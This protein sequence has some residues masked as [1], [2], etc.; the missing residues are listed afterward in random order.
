MKSLR[1]GLLLGTLV[2]VCACA[3]GSE[4]D[5][6][7]GTG[8]APLGTGGA[9]GTGGVPGTGGAALGTGGVPL[10]TGGVP[11]GTGGVPVGT[12]GVA[13]TGGTSGGSQQDSVF[14]TDGYGTSGD[15][16]GYLFTAIDE[17]GST[18][19]PVCGAA[20]SCY[21][22]SGK[23]VCASGNLTAADDSFVMIGF[24]LNQ[25]TTPPNDPVA[26]TTTGTG[27]T[28]TVANPGNTDLRIKVDVGGTEYCAPLQKV[29]TAQTISW[30]A[31]KTACWGSSGTTL[32][33]SS[34]IQA[35]A[36]QVPGKAAG[37][38]PYNYCL[39]NIAAA[40]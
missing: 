17:N 33:A 27:V 28:V 39:V 19:A 40:P 15:W 11:L 35:I 16:H 21:S 30:A 18:V 20:G 13:A 5:D 36:V 8:G 24:N 9:F 32:P 12:G 7:A 10:G 6:G 25:G 26:W 2:Q 23:K 1:I 3:V 4:V 34:A 37:T 22:T 29:S 31:F 14:A 38:T